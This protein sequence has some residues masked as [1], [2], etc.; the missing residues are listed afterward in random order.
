MSKPD[1]LKELLDNVT[2]VCSESSTTITIKHE[3]VK[4][5]LKSELVKNYPALKNLLKAILANKRHE[6]IAQIAQQLN[7]VISDEHNLLKNPQLE[8]EQLSLK[9]SSEIEESFLFFDEN[10]LSDAQKEVVL[11]FNAQAKELL[12]VLADLKAK[13][14]DQDQE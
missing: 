5:A 9:V 3:T 13:D 1:P 12:K 4:D 14:Q 8:T 7:S 2:S 6:I 10:G 11:K